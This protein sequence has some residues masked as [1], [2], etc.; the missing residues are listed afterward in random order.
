MQTFYVSVLMNWNVL[1][2]SSDAKSGPMNP[3]YSVIKDV[4]NGWKLYFQTHKHLLIS[5]FRSHCQG[6]CLLHVHWI[7][8]EDYGPHESVSAFLRLNS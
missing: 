8:T 3:E 6:L 2:L 7:I 4:A 1:L 5:P